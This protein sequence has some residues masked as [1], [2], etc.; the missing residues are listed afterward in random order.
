M[1]RAYKFALLYKVLLMILPLT[2]NSLK[3]DG[4][5]IDSIRKE[6]QKVS[7]Q[8]YV[9]HKKNFLIIDAILDGMIKLNPKTPSYQVSYSN[10]G[11]STH[12]VPPADEPSFVYMFRY[13]DGKITINN[14]PLDDV[15]NMVYANKIKN[16]FSHDDGGMPNSF[17]LSDY[18]GLRLKDI[19]M[20]YSSFRKGLTLDMGTF[21]DRNVVNMLVEDK[22]LDTTYDYTVIYSQEGLFI[23]HI[24]VD[25]MPATKYTFYI[26]QNGF[27][28]SSPK[29]QLYIDKKQIKCNKSPGFKSK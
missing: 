17:T 23:N 22:L 21:S 25:E 2:L 18:F 1:K 19:F 28:P 8:L 9:E 24:K 7:T 11:A 29:D 27:S 20:P 6:M 5:N 12:T 4:Q 26:N 3:S 16:F 13:Q 14:K 15:A 10:G